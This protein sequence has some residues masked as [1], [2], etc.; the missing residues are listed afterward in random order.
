MK[1]QLGV[2]YKMCFKKQVP[3][4]W[5]LLENSALDVKRSKKNTAEI[6]LR[7]PNPSRAFK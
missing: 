3:N 7:D 6:A 1:D 2:L 5:N 4:I